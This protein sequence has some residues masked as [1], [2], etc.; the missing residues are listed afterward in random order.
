MVLSQLCEKTGLKE[1]TVCFYLQEGLLPFFPSGSNPH[2][3]PDFYERDAVWLAQVADL[4][5]A[6]F[7]L[8]DIRRM[9]K[10]TGAVPAVVEAHRRQLAQDAG[11]IGKKYQLVKG[12]EKIPADDLRSAGSVAAYIQPYVEKMP[13]PAMDRYPRQSPMTGRELAMQEENEALL[14]HRI[15]QDI[16]E[17]RGKGLVT[18]IVIAEGILLFFQAL[19]VMERFSILAG[20]MTLAISAAVLIAFARGIIWVKFLILAWAVTS[21]FVAGFVLV[22]VT[23]PIGSRP[24]VIVREFTYP[25]EWQDEIPPEVLEQQEMVREQQ[26]AQEAFVKRLLAALL[27]MFIL[28]K[29]GLCVVLLK[30]KAIEVYMY[31]MRN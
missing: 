8:S 9:L 31:N 20:L 25:E 23:A 13:L 10:D 1:P 22:D 21:I 29:L 16:Q 14:L 3:H 7:P 30:S 27:V 19:G 18:A 28:Y 17:R 2:T 26:L 15:E 11:I 12:L 6:G 24:G 5:R 4:R